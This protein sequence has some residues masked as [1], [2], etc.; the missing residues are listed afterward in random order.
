MGEGVNTIEIS[1]TNTNSE[2]NT[3][4]DLCHM[5][6]EIINKTKL[7]G[8]GAF[9]I[10]VA[11]KY[12]FHLLVREVLASFLF[13]PFGMGLSLVHRKWWF[14][15]MLSCMD[16]DLRKVLKWTHIRSN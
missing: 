14:V 10:N 6:Y 13:P 4:H 12:Q 1:S 8:S 2:A 9:A 5:F 11:A 16:V 15:L 7:S 3:T